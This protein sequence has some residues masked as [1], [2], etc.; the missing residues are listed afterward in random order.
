MGVGQ[1]AQPAP[2]TQP[3]PQWEE[4]SVVWTVAVPSGTANGRILFNGDVEQLATL[5]ANYA[6]VTMAGAEV[7]PMVD[8]S[9]ATT[10]SLHLSFD[11]DRSLVRTR[12]AIIGRPGSVRVLGSVPS[13]Q[14]LR[15][16]LGGVH[17]SRHVNVASRQGSPGLVLDWDSNLS[18]DAILKV[19]VHARCVGS[20]AGGV[21]SVAPRFN[22]EGFS[23]ATN[24]PGLLRVVM[25][26]NVTNIRT[27]NGALQVYRSG[28][29][30]A[31]LADGNGVLA[32]Q[33]PVSA[34]ALLNDARWPAGTYFFM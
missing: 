10:G 5:M 33:L 3:R 25:T 9:A 19:T 11:T 22:G 29:W 28:S 34:P 23:W 1:V 30:T 24:V 15:A 17:A 26:A 18:V 16:S 7:E 31:M 8:G 6:T 32:S 12:A 27:V 2:A 20:L 4:R 13:T 14:V 21:T